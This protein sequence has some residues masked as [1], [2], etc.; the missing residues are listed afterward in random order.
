M[1]PFRSI[2][3]TGTAEAKQKKLEL[4]TAD[5]F[6]RTVVPYRCNRVVMFQSDLFHRSDFFEFDQQAY[7]NRRTNLT[8]LFGKRV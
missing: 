1:R 6:R 5:G 8:Y 7:A 2:Y 4:L 3:N